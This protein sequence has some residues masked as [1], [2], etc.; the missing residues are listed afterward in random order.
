MRCMGW[1]TSESQK[2]LSCSR[3]L[4]RRCD[5]LMAP[6]GGEGSW[7]GVMRRNQVTGTFLY[8]AVFSSLHN[9]RLTFSTASPADPTE[10]GWLSGLK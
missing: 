4:G 2:G 9:Q 8:V 10:P 6:C 5:S 1:N 3:F 7:E